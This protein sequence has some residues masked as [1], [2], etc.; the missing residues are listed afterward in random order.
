MRNTSGACCAQ[1]FSFGPR[2]AR[3]DRLCTF[4]RLARFP[5]AVTQAVASFPAETMDCIFRGL[6][7]RSIQLN[8]GN[9]ETDLVLLRS[10]NGAMRQLGPDA[11]NAEPCSRCF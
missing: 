10:V 2:R 4:L 5:S 7:S 6:G 8:L 1:Y 11:A 3:R 9:A